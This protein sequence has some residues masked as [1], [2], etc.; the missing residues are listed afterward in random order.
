MLHVQ[1]FAGRK[2]YP[3][4]QWSIVGCVT[5]PDT[6]LLGRGRCATRYPD[7]R[8][9]GPGSLV[10]VMAIPC[11]A[12]EKHLVIGDSIGACS[13]DDRTGPRPFTWA[14]C[15]TVKLPDAWSTLLPV[16]RMRG[17]EFQTCWRL[18]ARLA[19]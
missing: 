14:S 1:S 12:S 15:P 7:Q 16:P 9:F 18:D 17:F 6:R 8:R 2:A 19:Q 5:N 11:P 10:C 13:R 3:R 4:R